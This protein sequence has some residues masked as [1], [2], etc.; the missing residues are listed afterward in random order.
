MKLCDQTLGWIE[1]LWHIKTGSASELGF[2]KMLLF[3][4]KI[5]L[6][7]FSM[8]NLNQYEKIQF[9]VIKLKNAVYSVWT[10]KNISVIYTRW[11]IILCHKNYIKMHESTQ[12]LWQNVRNDVNL[13]MK[14]RWY[15]KEFFCTTFYTFESGIKTPIETT[16]RTNG[17]ML[18]INHLLCWQLKSY[19]WNI[20]FIY[21]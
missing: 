16:T 1:K 17:N 15:Q 19:T 14:T 10:Y 12:I 20:T 6:K 8:L 3:I 4:P 18:S 9:S 13:F 11:M 5:R 2:A 21:V 7:L